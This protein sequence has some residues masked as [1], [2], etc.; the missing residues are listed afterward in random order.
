MT[1]TGIITAG[2]LTGNTAISVTLGGANV[3]TNLAAFT[4]VGLT[5][6]DSAGGLNVTGTVNGGTG[7]VSITTAGGALALAR[8]TSAERA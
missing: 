4:S 5:L 3:L 7:A 6:N 2:T 8:T 1:Q